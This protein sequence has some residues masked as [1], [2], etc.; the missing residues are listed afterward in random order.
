MN[1]TAGIVMVATGLLAIAKGW[2]NHA[3]TSMLS[4]KQA[5]DE[6]DSPETVS[7]FT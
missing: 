1:V 4:R 6:L 5:R 7:A 2:S 3:E